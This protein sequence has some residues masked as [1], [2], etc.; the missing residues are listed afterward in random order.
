MGARRRTVMMRESLEEAIVRHLESTL[1]D[2]L[3]FL[4]R[5]TATVVSPASPAAACL[6]ICLPLKAG[7]ADR[8]C[9]STDSSTP[10]FPDTRRVDLG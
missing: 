4:G 7:T 8:P 10:Q 1:G 5:H 9:T 3:G 6:P 2:A